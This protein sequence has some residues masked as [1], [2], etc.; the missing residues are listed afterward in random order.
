MVPAK[1]SSF[2]L[3]GLFIFLSSYSQYQPDTINENSVKDI[4]A[5]L[6]SDKLRGRVNYSKEQWDAADFIAKKFEAYELLPF[7]GFQYYF[8]PFAPRTNE[9]LLRII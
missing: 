7:P 5:Y 8:Q 1:K 4:L 6:A 3:V 9:V 2:V